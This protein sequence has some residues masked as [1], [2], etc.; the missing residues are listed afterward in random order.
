MKSTLLIVLLA[1]LCSACSISS[2]TASRPLS[3]DREAADP[4]NATLP[5]STSTATLTK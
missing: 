4:I 2:T 1:G 5:D 3:P